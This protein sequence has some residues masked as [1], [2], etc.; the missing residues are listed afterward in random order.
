MNWSIASDLVIFILTFSS[1]IFV[2]LKLRFKLDTPF[3]LTLILI[4]TF[5][6]IRFINSMYLLAQRKNDPSGIDSGV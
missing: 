5:P 6:S 2:V 1:E 4:L 3:T